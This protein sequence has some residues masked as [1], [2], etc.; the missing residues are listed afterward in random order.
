[1]EAVCSASARL[2]APLSLPEVLLVAVAMFALWS[3]LRAIV[4]GTDVAVASCRRWARISTIAAILA[5]WSAVW[6][7]IDTGAL[8][9]VGFAAFD[10]WFVCLSNRT[11]VPRAKAFPAGRRPR[12]WGAPSEPRN[13]P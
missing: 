10:C 7:R 5:L 9:M 2:V 11:V 3:L 13:A 8:A 4:S 12:G 1:M 6:A